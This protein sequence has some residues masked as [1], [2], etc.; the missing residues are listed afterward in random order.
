MKIVA[1]IGF[2]FLVLMSNAQIKIYDDFEVFEKEILT[3]RGETIHVVNFWATWCGPCV[4]ELPYFEEIANHYSA[5][6]VKLT[7]VSLDFVKQIDRKLIPFIKE[8]NILS[9]VVLLDVSDPNSWIDRVD[10]AWSGAI[11]ITLIYK[12]GKKYFYEREFH[13]FEELEELID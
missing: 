8:N 1:I 7:L 12:N 9:E 6:E 5:K 2:T 4:K 3:D 13:S 11:P 10:P